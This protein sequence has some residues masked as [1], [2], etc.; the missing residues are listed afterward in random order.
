MSA[1]VPGVLLVRDAINNVI[2]EGD[3]LAWNVPKDTTN[4]VVRAARVHEGGLAMG[5]SGDVTPPVLTVMIDI[6][7]SDVRK[8]AEA[9]LADFLCIRDPRSE[10]LLDKVT[11]GKAS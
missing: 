2:K 5:A 10:Q 8:G 1:A 7:I 6:P 4:I 3:L 9:R 11:G